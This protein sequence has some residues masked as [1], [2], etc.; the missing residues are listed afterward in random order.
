MHGRAVPTTIHYTRQETQATQPYPWLCS[1]GTC[2]SGLAGR[3]R[4][5][6]SLSWL[7]RQG[8]CTPH[9]SQRLVLMLSSSELSCIQ[10]WYQAHTPGLACL[11]SKRQN[12][13]Q[14]NYKE[15]PYRA[16]LYCTLTCTAHA[17]MHSTALCAINTL[18]SAQYSC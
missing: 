9:R 13:H 15:Q 11:C 8:T 2:C 4:L 5:G 18:R 1:R 14:K 3:P 12:I 17:Y 7:A 6:H 10:T 16:N